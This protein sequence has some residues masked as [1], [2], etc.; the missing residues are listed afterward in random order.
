MIGD[1]RGSTMVSIFR[2]TDQPPTRSALLTANWQPLIAE[3]FPLGDADA[4]LNAL[5]S[6]RYAGKVVLST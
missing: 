1:Y 6:R 4:A 2:G 3:T 5:L